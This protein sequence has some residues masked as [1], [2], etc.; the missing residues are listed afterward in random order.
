MRWKLGILVTLIL[1]TGAHSQS[2]IGKGSYS[3]SG[4]IAFNSAKYDGESK[5]GTQFLFNPNLHYF[6][7]DRISLGLNISFEQLRNPEEGINNVERD[8]NI[9][10]FGPSVRYYFGN[11]KFFPFVQTGYYYSNIHFLPGK[12]RISSHSL[13]VGAGFDFYLTDNLGIE[14]LASFDDFDNRV[15]GYAQKVKATAPNN[16]SIG[17]TQI[18]LLVGIFASF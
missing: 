18:G 10:A 11:R 3:V 12:E 7:E 14:V 17:S 4:S 8:L 13:N 1:W 5:S 16:F 6:I 15:K 2:Q 9:I